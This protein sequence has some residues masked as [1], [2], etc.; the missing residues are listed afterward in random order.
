MASKKKADDSNPT[1]KTQKPRGK[2]SAPRE[3]AK[4]RPAARADAASGKAAATASPVAPGQPTGKVVVSREIGGRTLTLETGRMAKLSDGAIVARYG[5]TMVLA[6]VN[7]AKAMATD[8]WGSTDPESRILVG[9]RSTDYPHSAPT[10]SPSGYPLR[11]PR[12]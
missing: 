3:G 8:H 2:A 5:D 1:E 4:A 10:R 12:T 7:N 9:S 11:H 6:T